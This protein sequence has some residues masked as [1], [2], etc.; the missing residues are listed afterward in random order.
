M[1]PQVLAPP[2]RETDPA[3]L[4]PAAPAR[5]DRP[6]ISPPRKRAAISIGRGP[7]VASLLLHGAGLALMLLLL[8]FGPPAAPER[9]AVSEQVE[10]IDLSWPVGVP[11]DGASAES[12]PD[13]LPPVPGDQPAA[14]RQRNAGPLVFPGR[15]PNGISAPASGGVGPGVAGGSAEPSVGGLGDRLRPGFRDSRLYV[16]P[17]AIRPVAEKTNQQKYM[18][19]LTARIEASNDSVAGAARTPDTDWTVKDGSGRRW[20]LSEKGLH[21]G[22]LTVPSALIPKPA[23]TGS[24]QK[25]EEARTEQQ[26]RDEIRRQEE[27]RARREAREESIRE[28]RERA[29]ARR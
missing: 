15:V 9:V 12:A 8:R 28:A 17:D 23:A 26:Q 10:Y 27:E 18:E 22:S 1:T 4:V 13:P 6:V 25:R 20:G 2:P 5:W 14:S 19:H 16:S 11:G 7:L 21:L 24:N 29:D 3:T